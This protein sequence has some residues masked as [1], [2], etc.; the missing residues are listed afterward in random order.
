MASESKP[1]SE[2]CLAV[3]VIILILILLMEMPNWVINFSISLNITLGVVLL[4]ISL[5]IQK[6]L[7]LAAFP[8]IILLGTM[9]RLVLSIASTRLILSKGEAGEVIDAFGH[10]VTGGNMVV[11]GVIFLI[12]TVVQFM[13]ITKGAERIAEVSARFALDAMPGKQMTIDADFN[14]GLISPEEAVKKREDL[15]RESSLFGSMDGAM[16]FVKGDTMAGIIITIINIVGGLIIGC[17]MNGMAPAEAVGKYTILTIGDGLCAQVPSLLM[18]I[19]AGIVMTRASADAS[20][21]GSDLTSQIMS[22]PYSLFFAA[23]FLFLITITCPITGLPFFPFLLFSIGLTVAGFSVLINADVQSQLGQLENVRQNMQDLVNPNKMYERLGVDVLSL[24]VGAGLLVIADP[25]QEGQ[26]LAKI[27]ALRQRVTDELGYIL[28]NIRIMDSSALETNEYMISIRGNTVATGYV[29]PGKYMVIADQWDAV[30]KN[31]PDDAIIAVDPT[32]QTQAYWISGEDAQA[33]KNITAVDATDVL[34]THLQECVRKH[35][36]EVMTKTDVL[37]LM[38]LVRSQDPTL[39]NDLVPAIIST[40]DLRKIFVNL[41][42]EKVSIKDIIFVFERLCD[43]ARFSKEPDILSERLRAALGRQI[44]LTNVQ[45]DNI[46]Y[47]LTLSPEWE[48][49]LDDSCQRTELGTMFL[50]NPM[51]VQDLIES[52]AMTLMRAHQNIGKQPVILCSPRIR[53]PLFQLLE[54][55]IPTIVVISYSEL[56]TDIRV[57][58]VDTIG[59]AN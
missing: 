6:P 23:A 18:S 37:K 9:F 15:Q 22:K 58:A 50:L 25:D 47:A 49:V 43:Y 16:K 53:L 7:E 3:F 28:P 56:I 38:E 14:A 44:C 31:V 13:V 45:E 5:Y 27:A 8:T 17:L 24:Q 1:I 12:I 10:F 29:Y 59:E 36:D 33:N 42:R 52:T 39:V 55:H 35:V 26:L 19:A 51:Q 4:M 54:R 40:S 21:L 57:E 41:I 20:S 48:K 46:L 32:Y 2:I 30:R 34:V 11:G